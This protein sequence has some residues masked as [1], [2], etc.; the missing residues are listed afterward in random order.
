MRVIIISVFINTDKSQICLPPIFEQRQSD[1]G[2][3]ISALLEWLQPHLLACRLRTAAELMYKDI[4]NV[5][6]LFDYDSRNYSFYYKI[7]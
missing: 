3:N 5:K 6:V 4:A 2:R 1:F 7:E